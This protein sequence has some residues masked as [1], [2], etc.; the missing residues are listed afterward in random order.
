MHLLNS[1]NTTVVL[2]NVLI[3][4]IEE[5]YTNGPWRFIVSGGHGANIT[6]L[7]DSEKEARAEL[8]KL[9]AALEEI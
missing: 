8:E 3:V 4:S 9:R 1:Q 5:V 2:E 6:S 7:Y